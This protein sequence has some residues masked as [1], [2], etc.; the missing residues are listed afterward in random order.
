MFWHAK[1]HDYTFDRK[2]FDD[3]PPPKAWEPRDRILEA[4]ELDRLLE[5]TNKMYVKREEWKCLILWQYY[6]CMRAGET[7][8]MKWDEIHLDEKI[9]IIHTSLCRRKTP[10]LLIRR[11]LRIA[12][13][14]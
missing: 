5:A 13:F 12:R 3:N 10:R 1:H 14:H 4:G 8:L 7:L 6:S 9:H 2:P 11:M